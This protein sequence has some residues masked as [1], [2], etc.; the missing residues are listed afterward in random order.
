MRR[1]SALDQFRT[2]EEQVV[3]R[4]RELKPLVAEYQD[5]SNSPSASA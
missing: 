1:V 5:T 2:A 3:N 4:L